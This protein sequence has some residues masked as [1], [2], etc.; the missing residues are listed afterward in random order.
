MATLR[1][2]VGQIL[3]ERAGVPLLTWLMNAKQDG[4]SLRVIA[5]DIYTLTNMSV[6]HETVR[7]WLVE[8]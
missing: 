5:H 2:A 4:K 6:S 1:E 3:E 7:A 8:G